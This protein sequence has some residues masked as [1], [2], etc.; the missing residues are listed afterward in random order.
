MAD[1]ATTPRRYGILDL[2]DVGF[3]LPLDEPVPAIRELYRRA[4]RQSWDP[5]TAIPWE[6]ADPSRY[7]SDQI[8]AA[9]V[10]WSR[11]AWGEYGAISESP[12]MQLR[13]ALERREP[14]LSLYWTIRTQEE[15]R[16]AEVCRRMAELLGGYHL[17]PDE[18]ELKAIAGALGTRER[19]LDDAV[20][21]EATVAGLMCVAETVVYDVFLQLVKRVTNPVAKQIFRLILRD[22]TRHCDFGWLLL[23]HRV[24]ALSAVQVESCT[25]AMIAMIEGVELAGY[26]S[27]WLAE[28]PTASEV[29]VD[30]IVFDA[31]LGGTR[32]EWEAPIVVKS[33]RDIRERA[34]RIGIELPEFHHEL[35]G[36]I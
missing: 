17:S 23:E 36:T 4:K 16:H 2:P 3:P 13:F 33:I 30:Q 6:Q 32:A 27:A 25:D 34:G 15:I 12:T 26:R 5:E 19:V 20:L 1:Q 11:R 21:L 24:P 7:S 28:N 18:E 31:G 9:R 10:Y 14:D 29:E 8:E 35:L 22:E